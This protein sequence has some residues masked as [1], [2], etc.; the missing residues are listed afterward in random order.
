MFLNIRK[1]PLS[2]HRHSNAYGFSQ[3]AYA[4][5]AFELINFEL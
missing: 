2:G 5:Y 4:R 3:F 1:I